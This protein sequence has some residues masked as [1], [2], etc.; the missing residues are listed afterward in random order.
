L[1]LNLFYPTKLTAPWLIRK[2]YQQAFNLGINASIYEK[3]TVKYLTQ[4]AYSHALILDMKTKV[5][6]VK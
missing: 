6:E 5:S 2:A 4:K 1:A 3:A